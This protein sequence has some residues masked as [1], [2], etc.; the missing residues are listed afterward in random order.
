M[1]APFVFPLQSTNEQIGGNNA[2]T[3]ILSSKEV[4]DSHSDAKWEDPWR[5]T[6][7][8]KQAWVVA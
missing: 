3:K 2:M 8:E 6:K 5:K 4:S 1:L 7:E